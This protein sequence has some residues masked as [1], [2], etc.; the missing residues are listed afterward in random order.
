MQ[1][2]I[3]YLPT[4]FLVLLRPDVTSRIEIS[5]PTF[6][7]SVARRRKAIPAIIPRKHVKNC[8]YKPLKLYNPLITLQCKTL[9][10]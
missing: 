9:L 5:L 7:L 1:P 8:K 6:L 10:N 3:L 2:Y 4:D